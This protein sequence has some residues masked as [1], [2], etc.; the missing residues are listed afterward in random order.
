MTPH[1]IELRHSTV[2]GNVRSTLIAVYADVRADQL[3][4][5]NYSVERFGEQLS[6]H[7]RSSRIVVSVNMFGEGFDLA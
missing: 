2:I 6:R 4:L 3:H 1:G 5:P 7:D